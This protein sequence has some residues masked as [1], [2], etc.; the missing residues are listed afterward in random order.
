MEGRQFLDDVDLAL[1]IEA[2]AGN[3]DEVPLFAACQHR[4]TETSEDTADLN[5]AEFLAE[6]SL[7]LPQI[8]LHRSQIKLAGDH[9]DHVADEGAAAR[10]EYKLRNPVRRSDGRFE[11]GAALE[12]VRS[13]CVNA[14]PLR[15][16]AHGGRVPPGGFDQDILRLLGDHGVE[17]AHRAGQS[18][19]FFCVGNDE[20]FAGKLALYAVQSLQRFAGPSFANHQAASFEQ[21]EIE[22]V[23]GLATLPQDVV[24]SVDRVADA[25][26]IEPLQTA[27]NIGPGRLNGDAA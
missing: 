21:I 9:I 14:V 11:I 27:G 7:H 8:E 25:P 3:V 13:V 6:N 5:R 1:D 17:A 24:G 18:H 15:H 19:R 4:E 26:L 22:N 16:P 2:P 23:G 12:S 10:S 20:I